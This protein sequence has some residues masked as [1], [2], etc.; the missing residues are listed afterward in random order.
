MPAA[1]SPFRPAAL[2]LM[3]G[4]FPFAL[5]LVAV[6]WSSGKSILD[7]IISPT[8]TLRPTHDHF[9]RRV[10]APTAAITVAV[11]IGGL[12][13]LSLL[14]G[15]QLGTA[16]LDADCRRFCAGVQYGFAFPYEATRGLVGVLL[17]IATTKHPLWLIVL[18]PTAAL[19][20][21]VLWRLLHLRWILGGI[22]FIMAALRQEP[23]DAKRCDGVICAAGLPVLLLALGAGGWLPLPLS[24]LYYLLW[25]AVMSLLTIGLFAEDKMIAHQEE[26]Q[27]KADKQ[28]AEAEA[29]RR[30]QDEAAEA[31][32]RAELG[33][34]ELD[35][36]FDNEPEWDF[37]DDEH[38][39]ERRRPRTRR[40]RLSRIPEK[41]LL[42][43][44]LLGGWPGALTAQRLLTHKIGSKKHWFVANLYGLMALHNGL[45]LATL[46][47]WA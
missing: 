11:W 10:T 31:L 2:F 17:N 29:E 15:W 36:G 16:A 1:E 3:V 47:A 20:A 14:R 8:L 30:R 45:A 5:V 39:D 4:L 25:V 38:F 21:C 18:V 44:V 35:G 24:A 22:L 32:L 26:A 6:V 33:E 23:P 27:K 37:D 46:Y 12:V 42:A 13:F 34:D 43:P 28:A 7:C 41:W 19:F 40:T 9:W